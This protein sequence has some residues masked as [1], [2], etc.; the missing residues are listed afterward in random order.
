MVTK[1]QKEL[2][3]N[4]DSLVLKKKC[5][6]Y[7]ILCRFPWKNGFRY[8][9]LG[10]K[11]QGNNPISQRNQFCDCYSDYLVFDFW[12]LYVNVSVQL[13]SSGTLTNV[14]VHACV[15]VHTCM[16][17]CVYKFTCWSLFPGQIWNVY[18]PLLVSVVS[19]L[20][21]LCTGF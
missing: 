7:E 17:A 19:F 12:L 11:W 4:E 3:G 13:R 21:V 8:E 9:M 6:K 18:F 10:N 5:K 14:R 2:S 1:I 16:R 15:C 20:I